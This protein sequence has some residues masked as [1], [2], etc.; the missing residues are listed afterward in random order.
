MAKKVFSL[1]I[2]WK[3]KKKRVKLDFEEALAEYSKCCGVDCCNNRI[4]GLVATD[5]PTTEVYITASTT[6]LSVVNAATGTVLATFSDTQ[7]VTGI[8]S[9]GEGDYTVLSTDQVVLK[10]AVT[11]LGDTVTLPSGAATG[12]IFT[13]KDGGDATGTDTI[14]IATAGAETID[15]AATQTINA[16]YGYIKVLFDGTNYVILDSA[17]LA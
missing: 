17:S 9:V 2:F 16:A 1:P 4:A 6:G 14:T 11:A 3:N 13:I 10:T 5:S 8:T 15:G 7:T 12:Q